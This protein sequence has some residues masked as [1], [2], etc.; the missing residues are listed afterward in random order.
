[1]EAR[2][3]I[4]WVAGQWV[5]GGLFAVGQTPENPC[6]APT[7]QFCRRSIMLVVVVAFL[8]RLGAAPTKLLFQNAPAH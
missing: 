5:C 2:R 8:S 3:D 7:P 1:M 6:S 4:D